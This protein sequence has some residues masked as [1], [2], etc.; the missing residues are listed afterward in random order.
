MDNHPVT[1]Q[2]VNRPRWLQYIVNTLVPLFR[3]DTRHR[4]IVGGVQAELNVLLRRNLPECSRSGLR[5]FN[6]PS[7][8]VFVGIQAPSPQ[9]F[10][11][12]CIFF[13]AQF[14]KALRIPCR[15]KPGFQIHN[16]FLRSLRRTTRSA[17]RFNLKNRNRSNSI[18]STRIE[19][20]PARLP[21]S[22]SVKIWSPINAISR[23]WT[24]SLSP[25]RRTPRVNG[26]AAFAMHPSP[27]FL[28]NGSTR[29]GR[30]FERISSLIPAFC[31]CAI[32]L[33]A[34]SGTSG[35]SW[36]VNVLST[37]SKTTEIWCTVNHSGAISQIRRNL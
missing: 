19:T 27:N 31:I 18:G 20:I 26:F 2:C 24:P 6:T 28:A 21:Q 14:R 34:S 7:A 35:L 36:V 4:D 13:I 3:V 22:I 32:H 1:P 12:L 8:L 15:A 9:I 25:A 17:A 23:F 10:R 16:S 30:L 29:S 11:D 33:R 5:N 37:S